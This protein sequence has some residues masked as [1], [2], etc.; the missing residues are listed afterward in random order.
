M[1]RFILDQARKSLG[2]ILRK[3]L[4]Q[5]YDVHY[6]II[7]RKRKTS[8]FLTHY[9]GSNCKNKLNKKYFIISIKLTLNHLDNLYTF[10]LTINIDN[11]VVV[12]ITEI[13]EIIIEIYYRNIFNI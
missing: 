2:G 3:I 9:D 10:L 11:F 13:R 4:H 1:L 5:I 8:P 12:K 7:P 6:L